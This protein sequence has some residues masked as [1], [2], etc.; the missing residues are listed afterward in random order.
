LI[1]K[2]WQKTSLIEYPGKISSV[3]FV[4]GCNFRCPFCYNGDLVEKPHHLGDLEGETVLQYLSENAGLYQALVI[5]GGEPTLK[6]QL[7]G[8]LRRV[9]ALDL[10]VGLETNGTNPNML[11]RMLDEHLLDFIAMDVKAPLDWDAYRRA[12]GLP[13]DSEDVIAEVKRSL[14]L[15]RETPVEVELRC[16]VVPRVHQPKDILQLAEQLKGQRSFVLQQFVP[17]RALDPGLRDQRPFAASVLSRL[18]KR[19]GGLFPRC[20][21]RGI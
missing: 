12:A 16:T 15:L 2:G 19:I 5:S 7:P 13:R 20:E 6:P 18:G 9:K 1:F 4:G 3:V 11:E 8:F 21:V 10:C 14:H 17:E